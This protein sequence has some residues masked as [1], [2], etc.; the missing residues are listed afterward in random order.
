[1]PK[2]L[3]LQEERGE[4]MASEEPTITEPINKA[5]VWAKQKRL[6]D[7]PW[8]EKTGRLPVEPEFTI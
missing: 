3:I 4:K 7:P 8:L 1:S 2:A 5:L 6:E